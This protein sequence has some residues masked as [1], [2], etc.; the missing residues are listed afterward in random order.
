MALPVPAIQ[1]PIGG[2]SAP[3]SMEHLIEECNVNVLLSTPTTLVKLA[4]FCR[5]RT[6]TFP[7]IHLIMFSGEPLFPDQE[8]LLHPVFPNA[9]FRSCIYGSIDAGVV[10]KPADDTDPRVHQLLPGIIAE[11]STDAEELEFTQEYGVE[12]SLVVTNLMRRLMPV[13]RYPIGDRAEWV[14]YKAGIFRLLGRDNHSLRLG[15]VSIDVRDIRRIVATALPDTTVTAL[16]AVLLRKGTKD[17]LQCRVDAS[18]VD[19]KA[20]EH[21]IKERLYKERPML[22]E[23]VR[24]GHIAEPEILFMSISEM[25]MN[26]VTGKLPEGL[27]LRYTN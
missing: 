24:S 27:D 8:L 20:A 16:Q 18:P 21:L 25:Q 6:K 10:A 12:G 9:K 7:K 4:N 17:L 23:H 2:F 15:P 19:R 1:V 26:S 5:P 22:A 3:D 13:V 11:I 14:D